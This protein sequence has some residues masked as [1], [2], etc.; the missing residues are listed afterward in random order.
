[1]DAEAV[2]KSVSITASTFRSRAWV[3]A[4]LSIDKNAHTK[5]THLP[6]KFGLLISNTKTVPPKKKK[7]KVKSCC[8]RVKSTRRGFKVRRLHNDFLARFWGLFGGVVKTGLHRDRRVITD[9]P[10]PVMA[11]PV[12][13]LLPHSTPR[14]QKR[15]NSLLHFID[16]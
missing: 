16:E 7:K 14:C 13:E 10:F 3:L 4:S 8:C 11:V 12:S 2:G 15:S 6:S 5:S 1:M 9:R